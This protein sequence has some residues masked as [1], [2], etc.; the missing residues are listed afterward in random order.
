MSK[1]ASGKEGER[2][3]LIVIKTPAQD[4][5][6]PGLKLVAVPKL[7]LQCCNC[8]LAGSHYI[9]ASNKDGTSIRRMAPVLQDIIETPL[10]LVHPHLCPFILPFGLCNGVHV[11]P[12]E[13]LVHLEGKSFRVPHCPCIVVIIRPRERVLA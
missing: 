12:Q 3:S 7:L 10:R 1:V 9:L 4:L 8:Q 2:L 13:K 6:S 5:R 11:L